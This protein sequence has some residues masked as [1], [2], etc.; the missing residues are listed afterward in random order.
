MHLGV[1]ASETRSS[2]WRHTKLNMESAERIVQDFTSREWTLAGFLPTTLWRRH[3]LQ[4]CHFEQSPRTT[5]TLRCGD[6]CSGMRALDS[7]KCPDIRQIEGTRSPCRREEGPDIE[8][9][10][11]MTL[12]G[13]RNSRREPGNIRAGDH[14]TQIPQ[15]PGVRLTFTDLI[16][17]LLYFVSTMSTSITTGQASSISRHLR[18]AKRALQDVVHDAEYVWNGKVRHAGSLKSRFPVS[19]VLPPTRLRLD[20]LTKSSS[21]Q[22]LTR[23]VF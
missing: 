1:P 20:H 14:A 6:S 15:T 4:V 21:G 3:F 5:T 7:V 18:A 12:R 19:R 16:I 13:G 11:K 10:A 2:D 22:W 8:S 17:W 23:T 9:M